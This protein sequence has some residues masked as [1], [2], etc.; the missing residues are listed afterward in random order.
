MLEIFRNYINNSKTS[1]TD[2]EFEVIKSLCIVKKLRKKQYLLQEGDTWKYHAFICKGCL[3]AY[4]IDDKGV[5]HTTKFAIENHW[6]G[7]RAALLSGEPASYNID[8]IEDS[9]LLLI[10]T[11]NFTTICR[12]IP[13][14]NEMIN[15][16]LN[17]SFVA[18][19]NRIHAAISYSAEENY[20][21]FLQ[22]SP[23]IANR[24]PQHM[25]ASYLGISPETL[26]RIRNQA[27][28]KQ[29]RDS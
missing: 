19:E 10:T 13:A 4:R 15:G 28:K 18:N 17:R 21:K 20:Q 8:A 5:E 22:N 12:E 26:S 6:T 23:D 25:I 7:D 11:E 14:F 29:S 3:R 27:A 9:V 16:I 1:I 24:V 2:A